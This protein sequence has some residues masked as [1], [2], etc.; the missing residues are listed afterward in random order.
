MAST[1]D[2]VAEFVGGALLEMM[3]H[4]GTSDASLLSFV[5]TLGWELPA[6]PQVLRDLD[7]EALGS[8]VA[9]LEHARRRAA[10][11]AEVATAAAKVV[12]ELAGVCD[13][14]RTL[15]ERLRAELP[16]PVI[17][18]TG[19]DGLLETRLIDHGVVRYLERRQRHVVEAARVLGLVT[20]EQRTADP[21]TLRSRHI[22]REVHR[23]RITRLF[24]DP[25][26]VFA[27]S[28][29]WGS[30]A[31]ALD[32]M[33]EALL[34]LSI[35]RAMPGR[36]AYPPKSLAGYPPPGR[37]LAVPIFDEGALQAR[38]GLFPGPIDN[39]KGSL[40]LLL[41][42]NLIPT[43]TVDLGGH[44]TLELVSSIVAP[45]VALVLHPDRAPDL[46][47]S[48]FG[49]GAPPLEGGLTITARFAGDDDSFTILSV[50][51]VK[52]AAKSSYL[53]G[54][55]SR[56]AGT[57]DAFVEIGVV[58]GK[59]AV[60]T[61]SGGV[62][63]SLLPTGTLE[64]DA[65]VAIGWS[66]Q[67]GT[68]FRGGAGLRL[69]VPA[70]KRLGPFRVDS[71][72]IGIDTSGDT[73]AGSITVSGAAQL[74]PLELSFGGLGARVTAQPRGRFGL[75]AIDTDFAE[76]TRIGVK[77]QSSLA[78]GGGEI[79][80]E[81]GRYAG[82]LSL[83]IGSIGVDAIGVLD[84]P[85]SAVPHAS[86]A[87]LAST[88]FPRQQLGLGFTLDGIGALVATDRRIDVDATRAAVRTG[89]LATL[90]GGGG[91][92]GARLAAL[93]HCFPPA[94]GRYV[95]GPYAEIG[96]GTPKIADARLAV[97]LEL[98]APVLV[99]LLGDIQVGLPTLEDRV[100]DLRLDV[101]GVLDVARRT[102]A[103]DAS[104]HDSSLA[105][106]PL[107]GDMALRL[108][109]GDA[110]ELV[111]SVGGF[112]PRFT[113]PAGFP[114]L[115]RL[116]LTAGDNPQLRLDAYLALTSNTAQV[117]AHADLAYHGAGFKIA[118]H[119]GFDALFEFV[120]F[121]F[122][123]D[124]SVSAS[125]SWHGHDLAS[126]HL[127]V[128]LAGP[129]PWHAVGDA[130]FSVLWWDVSVGFDET[131]GDDAPAPL[132][133]P[134]DVA[135]R[136]RDAL[137]QPTAWTPVLDAADAKYLVLSEQPGLRLHPLSRLAIRQRVVPFGEDITQ[138]GTIPLAETLRFELPVL[139]QFG[140]P[141]PV[142]DAF[143][144]AQFR[145]LSVDERLEAPSFEQL[146]GG[147]ELAPALTVS[148]Q[149]TRAG[150]RTDTFVSDRLA[151]PDPP[152]LAPASFVVGLAF[153]A[154]R[155]AVPPPA[156]RVG[157]LRDVAFTVATT[158]ELAAM[159]TPSTYM[160]ASAR[161]RA[162][163]LQVIAAAHAAD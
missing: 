162:P 58:G 160:A 4:R 87:M 24:S 50:D 96:W 106:Y 139:A 13:A 27:E 91:D 95:V 74:G 122:E 40:L 9:A 141:V 158:A 49:G 68:Y 92:V 113:P 161:A 155:A 137:G 45:L 131:W 134:P 138:F 111:L 129:H 29:G 119:A 149:S 34:Q 104:L 23:E 37:G 121:H 98:P 114:A 142:L 93:S 150:L 105:G 14:L 151:P 20:I 16:A 83:Q 116:A 35:E 152:P 85:T 48:P 51:A 15:P 5:R 21:A 81:P 33:L 77:L 57:S 46:V 102:L 22:H 75:G 25:R 108:G 154:M 120:P 90:L 6:V 103:I 61:S 117:G 18:A 156:P 132:L 144:P 43:V 124:I 1:L 135:A 42:A 65:D 157:K 70:H 115:R 100:V 133:P 38:V 112:H 69:E 128:A 47:A 99:A 30:E 110:P 26:S 76:P 136:V 78:S 31:I 143:A 63:A 147:I 3:P 28:I 64:L 17:A 84:S 55:I 146:A 97:V 11:D 12:I 80:H 88:T 53:S 148:P 59:L 118:A 10:D 73:L 32:V 123:V 7:V 86:F 72:A 153:H 60:D 8:A 127:D 2:R 54:G 163:G 79:D 94:L 101:L 107:T 89:E 130:T 82:S 44:L 62:L 125:I 140:T 159:T 145:R 67:R 126:V 36:Y 66:L 52:L 39:G 71:L 56:Q 109:W 41:A 19:I